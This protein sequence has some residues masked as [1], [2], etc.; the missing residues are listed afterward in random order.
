MVDFTAAVTGGRTWTQPNRSTANGM[1][2]QRTMI[3]VSATCGVLGIAASLTGLLGS[4]DGVFGEVPKAAL[5]GLL[6]SGSLLLLLTGVLMS[7]V[8]RAKRA[9]PS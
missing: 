4:E 1:F 6:F 8:A 5:I 9:S 7:I 3:P 2:W